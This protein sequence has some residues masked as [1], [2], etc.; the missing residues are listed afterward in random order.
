MKLLFF[1]FI[2]EGTLFATHEEVFGQFRETT[3]RDTL[4][5]PDTSLSSK[6]SKTQFSDIALQFLVGEV[7][8]NA[9][10]FSLWG[11]D[12]YK[13][14]SDNYFGVIGIVAS[15]FIVPLSMYLTSSALNLNTNFNSV[16][17][18][19]A[20]A[21]IGFILATVTHIQPVTYLSSY[22]SISLGIVLGSL[23]GY[24]LS[25]P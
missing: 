1:I 25:A 3:S 5:H 21:T 2:I 17:W 15:W 14:S 9:T 8:F 6:F 19:A 24:D 13:P 23:I 4:T 16:D 22:L 7:A 10:T 20:G 12:L 11:N 18:G